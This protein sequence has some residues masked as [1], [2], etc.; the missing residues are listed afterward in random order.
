ML[1]ENR[2]FISLLVCLGFWFGLFVGWLV[3]FVLF[4][5][6]F[7]GWV[8]FFLVMDYCF[9]IISCYIKAKNV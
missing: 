4:F 9:F 1:A 7:L 5:G 3:G 8:F 2:D 6:G